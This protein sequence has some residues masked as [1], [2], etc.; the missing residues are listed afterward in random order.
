MNH[1]RIGDIYPQILFEDR[2]PIPN[3]VIRLHARRGK[4]GFQPW[5]KPV[6]EF[7]G[8][9]SILERRFLLPLANYTRL[10]HVRNVLLFGD[11]PSVY[12]EL[13]YALDCF[14]RRVENIVLCLRPGQARG[15]ESLIASKVRQ[16]V[17]FIGPFA[18]VSS[19]TADVFPLLKGEIQSIRKAN[20]SISIKAVLYLSFQGIM[21]IDRLIQKV[22][23]AGFDR[24][25]FFPPNLFIG[26]AGER[27][28]RPM[29]HELVG[30]REPMVSLEKRFWDMLEE[31]CFESW[32]FDLNQTRRQMKRVLNYFKAALGLG[33]FSPPYCRASRIAFYVDSDAAIRCCPY[34]EAF[35][36]LGKKSLLEI[37]KGEALRYFRSNLNLARNDICPVCPG[38]YPH[39][40]WR[41]R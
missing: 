36:N 11:H 20:N 9:V 24:L 30:S 10:F 21:E 35:G 4:G 39:L 17:Y 26:G 37:S 5:D 16:I 29:G 34:Q 41:T 12:P 15:S 3:L 25:D 22:E 13:E 6:G 19:G 14:S 31:R 1:D 32:L 28:L 40:L 8:K 33:D 7:C 18:D 23:E 27:C 38:T 2:K